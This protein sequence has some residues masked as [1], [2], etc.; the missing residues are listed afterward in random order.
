MAASLCFK[1]CEDYSLLKGYNGGIWKKQL[2]V[3]AL[4]KNIWSV[5]LDSLAGMYLTCTMFL[6]QCFDF[7]KSYIM[8]LA[9]KTSHFLKQR[10]LRLQKKSL[11]SG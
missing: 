7:S 9:F 2:Q 8:I 1:S 6:M 5:L 3:W 4:K 10:S 11:I